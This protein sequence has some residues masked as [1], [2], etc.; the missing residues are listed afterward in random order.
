MA[1][2]IDRG[3]VTIVLARMGSQLT[4]YKMYYNS[5]SLTP[6][7]NRQ[8]KPS[9]FVKSLQSVKL[10]TFSLKLVDFRLNTSHLSIQRCSSL[11]RGAQ[12]V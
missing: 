4:R 10:L 12:G 8:T 3:A 6:K 7:P 9:R 1:L 5:Q 11:F 2:D